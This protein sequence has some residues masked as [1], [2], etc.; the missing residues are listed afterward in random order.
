MATVGRESTV[1]SR[2]T[3]WL[4]VYLGELTYLY[5]YWL[6]IILWLRVHACPG[7]V[8]HLEVQGR[9]LIRLE[10]PSFRTAAEFEDMQITF[11]TLS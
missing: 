2:E 5:V 6:Q 3:E 8:S 9:P 10:V 1:I 7:H 11:V 4:S